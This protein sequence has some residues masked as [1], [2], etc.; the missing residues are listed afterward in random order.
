[1]IKAVIFDWGRTLYDNENNDL[2]PDAKEILEYLSKKYKL[3]IVSMANSEEAQKR[4]V[5]DERINLFW[6][7]LAEKKPARSRH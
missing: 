7:E 3:A 5:E 1:M 6:K 4:K 2:F